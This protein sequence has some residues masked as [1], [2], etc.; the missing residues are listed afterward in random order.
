MAKEIVIW[1]ECDLEREE[2]V[3][4]T[5]HE[6]TIDGK[7]YTVDLC[8]TCYQ[9][10]IAP[11]VEMLAQFGQPLPAPRA[12]VKPKSPKKSSSAPKV[13]PNAQG[14][15]ECDYPGCGQTFSRPQGVG[16]HKL[17]HKDYAEVMAQVA[18]AS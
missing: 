3:P 4:G 10:H 13:L 9:K 1:C 18:A 17:A 15:F 12:V 16:R 2:R 7:A 14:E 11:V 8:P 6:V 5:E